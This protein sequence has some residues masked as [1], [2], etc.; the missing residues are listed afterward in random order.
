MLSTFHIYEVAIL[1]LLATGSTCELSALQFCLEPT[2]QNEWQHLI[3]ALI[4]KLL[5]IGELNFAEC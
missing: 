3:Q 1:K 5:V 4:V 2:N